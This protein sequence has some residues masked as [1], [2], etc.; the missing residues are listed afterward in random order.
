MA[1]LLTIAAAAPASACL[2][3]RD[4]LAEEIK[5]LP[6]VTQIITGRFERNPPLYYEMRIKRLESEIPAHPDVLNNYDDIAVAL[7]RVHRDDE[8]IRWEERKRAKLIALNVSATDPATKENWYRYYANC[9]TCWVH[10]WLGRGA[11][12]KRIAE[13][14]MARAMIAKAIAIKPG[15]HE[16]REKY[17]LLAM[18]WIIKRPTE[19]AETVAESSGS[20]RNNKSAK[21]APREYQ[22]LNNFVFANQDNYNEAVT[23]LTGLV[24]LG[25][26]W[27]SVDVFTAIAKGLEESEPRRMWASKLAYLRTEELFENGLHSIN[28][29]NDDQMSAVA[30]ISPMMGSLRATN[31]PKVFKSMRKE[32]DEWQT[33]RTDY[34]MARLTIGR[35]PDTD[36]TF[37]H[38]WHEYGPPEPPK[39]RTAWLWEALGKP[40]G[41]DDRFAEAL[42]SLLVVGF[43]ALLV[44]MTPVFFLIRA[45][46]LERRWKANRSADLERR[47]E[48]ESG[49][50]DDTSPP[51]PPPS[52]G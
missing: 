19:P 1:L 34:M 26:A 5:G 30:Q 22:T 36:A 15:A 43:V 18:D 20:Q 9:G 50:H 40:F 44:F 47:T 32:A 52:A 27:E 41:S 31:M 46:R 10:R 28:P 14:K 4:T 6:E 21:V 16:G 2:N 29:S 11:D 7:D 25:G 3:D 12:R 17:Q 13:V 33:K 42:P 51:Q 8:A 45:I 24:V 35:H 39:S 23:G 49:P 38:E 37:W 48:R